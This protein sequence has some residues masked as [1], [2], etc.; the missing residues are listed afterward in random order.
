MRSHQ[1]SG[2]AAQTC[3]LAVYNLWLLAGKASNTTTTN[4]TNTFLCAQTTRVIR[5]NT[6]HRPLVFHAPARLN[7]SGAQALI[8]T[9]HTTYNKQNEVYIK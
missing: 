5:R 6:T 9:V 3:G 8:P 1:A 7:T 4:Q 2:Q